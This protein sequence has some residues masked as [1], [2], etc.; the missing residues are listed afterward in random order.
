MKYILYDD[1]EKRVHDILKED[2][3]FSLSNVVKGYAF[4]VIKD[5]TPHRT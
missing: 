4:V 1:I 2:V 3:L 5:R